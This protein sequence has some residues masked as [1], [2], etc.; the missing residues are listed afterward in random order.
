MMKGLP[1]L[2][3]YAGHTD[4]SMKTILRYSVIFIFAVASQAMAAFESAKLG[5]EN[6]LP[7]FPLG[8]VSDGVIEGHVIF[9]VSISAEGKVADSLALQYTHQPFVR[10][11]QEAM[12]EWQVTPARL[13]GVSVPVQM[14][15]R[16]DF[17]REGFVETNSINISN[18]YI[19][20][21]FPGLE[22]RHLAYR[23]ARPVELDHAPVLVASVGP[24]YAKQAEQQG[25][26]GKVQ[27]YFYINEKGEVRFPSVTMEAHPYLS[28]IAVTALRQWRF[29]PPTH[30]GQPVLVA[31]TQVFDFGGVK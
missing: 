21:K 18:H 27:V 14:E 31:A 1:E 23:L 3:C 4:S 6:T 19:Y 30:Q 11:C 16:F 26:R 10:A 12:K 28:D 5:S 25:V 13:D 22:V 20:S 24:E 17:R 29:E 9:A 2:W 15:L 8:L 7:R